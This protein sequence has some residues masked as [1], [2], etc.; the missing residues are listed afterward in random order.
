MTICNLYIP[1]SQTVSHAELLNLFNQIPV[2]FIICGDINCHNPLW[3][4]SKLDKKGSIFENI[5]DQLNI[6]VMNSP[7]SPTHFS[8]AHGSYSHIDVSFISPGI[9]TLFN[10]NT[11]SD[12]GSSDHF[13]IIISV[14]Q[15]KIISRRPKWKIKNADWRGFCEE[16]NLSP[17]DN[18]LN[19][20]EKSIFIS[21]TIYSAAVS[22][23]PR[24]T[25]KPKRL[26]V[27]WW[28]EDISKARKERIKALRNFDRCPTNHNLAIFKRKRSI[29]KYLII[30][31]KQKSWLEYVE[32][33]NLNTTSS[34]VWRK[35]KNINSK[36][37]PN[38]ILS[39][40]VNNTLISNLSDILKIIGTYFKNTFSD[41]NYPQSFLN[42]KS[43]TPEFCIDNNDTDVSAYNSP[44][45]IYELNSALLKSKGSSPGPD[46]ISNEMLKHLDIYQR[47]YL[48]N[49]FNKIWS[50]H[51]FPNGWSESYLIPIL[52]PGKDPKEA[53]SY[54]PICL[55]NVLSK[56]MQRMVKSRLMWELD[57]RDLLNNNQFGFRAKRSTQDC[58]AILESDIQDSFSH[59]HQLTAIF[60]DL[61]KAFDRIWHHHVLTSLKNMGISGNML[62]FI[63]NFLGNRHFKVA[64]EDNLSDSYAQ[65]NGVPQGEVLSPCLFIIALTSIKNIIPKDVK[66]ILY[67]DDLTIY[68]SSSRLSSI[69]SKLQKTLDNLETWS[70]NIGLKFSPSKTKAIH[71]YRR[72][73]HNNPPR[74]TFIQEQLD[75]VNTH[76]FLGVVFDNRL[77]WKPHISAL[78]SV[79]IK[80]CN[81][82]KTLAGTSWGAD[83][84]TL[85]RIYDSLIQS[86]LDYGAVVYSSATNNVL[87]SLDSVLNQGIRISLGAFKSTPI[88]SLICEAG[89]IKLSLRREQQLLSFYV[90]ILQNPKHIL[91]N[92]IINNIHPDSKS[93]IN[94][95]KNIINNIYLNIMP[96]ILKFSPYLFPPWM[97][98]P[99]VDKSLLF[100][101]QSDSLQSLKEEFHRTVNRTYS[102]YTIMYTDGSKDQKNAGASY[103]SVNNS[104]SYRIYNEASISTAE[105][106]AI[107]K[108]IEFI[109]E[110]HLTNVLLCTDSLSSLLMFEKLYSS[111]PI[112]LSIQH[113]IF[114]TNTNIVFYWVPGHAGI[115]GNES[116]DTL[117]KQA[118]NNVNIELISLV[119]NDLINHYKINIREKWTQYWTN[120]DPQNKLRTIKNKTTP[121][122]FTSSLSR[123]DDVV[124]TRIR[125]G[126]CRMTH[127]YLMKK[128]AQPNCIHCNT[129]FTMIHVFEICPAFTQDRI[130]CNIR[131]IK[132]SAGDDSYGNKQIIQFLKNINLYNEI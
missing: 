132:Q 116:A 78:K 32:S 101:K 85:L 102:N 69:K 47:H 64:L 70:N 1:P 125:L 88:D 119:P 113:L 6:N 35:I 76:K 123:K 2:P 120:I 24:T 99:K 38:T 92:K 131:S 30:N 13:P 55:T 46:Q 34:D 65:L 60:F 15:P 106:F 8:A 82:L 53:A 63:K 114:T 59:K 86:R 17:V 4:S 103:W 68:C 37:V 29:C 22:N 124:L 127:D 28:N 117:A 48:L 3:G 129:P 23:I 97:I 90:K 98:H 77:T 89:K 100:A 105:L 52:K 49:Y 57:K 44:F 18:I 7:D 115:S 39:L 27:P 96:P 21:N 12:L 110:N 10:W 122:K 126:H 94:R 26:P 54:R 61:E 5:L 71:F 66:Y 84:R 108:C 16:V 9:H 118:L 56:L 111:H 112:V 80:K 50:E 104:V 31:A 25:N 14:N 91:F 72:R 121:W 42:I 67:A 11:H 93:L 36:F 74:L 19:I 79:T 130:N 45:T 107:Q 58:I 43:I 73:K 75:F 109:N 51:V 83:R 81:I 41:V 40:D 33:I 62:Y 95:T 128:E 87:A 20:D